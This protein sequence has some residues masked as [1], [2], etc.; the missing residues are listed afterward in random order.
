MYINKNLEG[1]I[2]DYTL[3]PY[4]YELVQAIEESLKPL[5]PYFLKNSQ[6][7]IE[8]IIEAI[9]E[10]LRARKFIVAKRII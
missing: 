9:I 8:A 4:R 10:G 2:I 6:P 5:E 7:R 3:E 1:K